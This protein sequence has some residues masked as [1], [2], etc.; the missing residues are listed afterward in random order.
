MFSSKVIQ[1]CID[2]GVIRFINVVDNKVVVD[3]S[4]ETGFP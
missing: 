4:L 3:G 1:A 2:F